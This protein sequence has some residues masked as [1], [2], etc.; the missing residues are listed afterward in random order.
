MSLPDHWYHYLITGRVP[1]C[2]CRA[3]EVDQTTFII[4]L[5]TNQ[6]HSPAVSCTQTNYYYYYYHYD[7][8]Y[9]YHYYYYKLITP[10]LQPRPITAGGRP[11]N[12]VV[13]ASCKVRNVVLKLQFSCK[14][15]T[16]STLDPVHVLRSRI[17]ICMQNFGVIRCAVSEFRLAS[18]DRWIGLS[19]Y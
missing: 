5:C 6:H 1:A 13:A 3:E 12:H 4:L 10:G 11:S 18:I 14:W 17:R 9:H 15:W 2:W 16:L 19:Y 8:H 7:Y